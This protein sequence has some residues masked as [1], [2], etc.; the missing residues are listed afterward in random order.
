MRRPLRFGFVTW[1][2]GFLGSCGLWGCTQYRGLDNV[3]WG[4]EAH[5]AVIIVRNPQNNIANYLGFYSR[6]F[7]AYWRVQQ[8]CGRVF[9]ISPKVF[10]LLCGSDS[11]A[12]GFRVWGLGFRV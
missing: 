9:F 11:G 2:E 3:N 1:E 5:C 10:M 8:D 6:D 7:R 4:F 12:L